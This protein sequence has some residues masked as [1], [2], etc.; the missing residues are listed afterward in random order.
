MAVFVA[1]SDEALGGGVFHH[2]GYLAPLACWTDVIVPAWEREVLAGLP[3]IDE[4]HVVDL[5]SRSWRDSH[6]ITKDDAEA[7]IDAA[8]EILAKARGL[9]AVRSSI[10]GDHFDEHSSGLRFRLNDPR[11]GPADF[12]TD[13]P[14]F[15][16]YIYS[17]LFAC[18]NYPKTEKVDFVI[19][20]KKEVFP[21]IHDFYESIRESLPGI[22]LSH[23]AKIMGELIPGDKKRIPLQAADLLCWHTQRKETN[24]RNPSI[25]FCEVDRLRYSKI[26][27]LGSGHT[28]SRLMIEEL[29]DSLFEDWR[30]LN[31]VEGI[32]EIRSGNEENP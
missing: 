15:L 22:G 8:V 31:E 27:R 3:P 17:V 11:R 24:A 12:V 32:S 16:G 9:Y 25:T 26:T 19:E 4:F 6:G 1:A 5:R 18:T 13:Y 21:A 10:D 7:R 2:A 23:I 14:S 20:K 30:K 29:C 28:W